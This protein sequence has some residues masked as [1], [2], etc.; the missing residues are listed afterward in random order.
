MSIPLIPKIV[1][2]Q[3]AYFMKEYVYKYYFSTFNI[4]S[5]NLDK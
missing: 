2:V 3:T 4:I 5:H 1:K